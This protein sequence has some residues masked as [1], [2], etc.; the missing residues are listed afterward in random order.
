MK[1]IRLRDLVR[2]MYKKEGLLSFYKGM[3][4]PMYSIPIINSIIFGCN[5]VTK[6]VLNMKDEHMNNFEMFI[7]G[8]VAGFLGCSVVTPAELVKCRM[9][10]QYESKDKAYY[11]GAFD[12]AIKTYKDNGIRGLYSGNLITILRE[13]PGYSAQ[14]AGYHLAKIAISKITG[15]EYSDNYVWE[16]MVAGGFAGYCCWQA[17][18]PKVSTKLIIHNKLGPY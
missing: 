16:I 11:K 4:F 12:C 10:L 7:S 2:D 17:S 5:E 6:H 14:F 18:Y 8:G 13:V 1:K 9:Q 3:S 15:K